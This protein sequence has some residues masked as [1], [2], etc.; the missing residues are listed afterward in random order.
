MHRILL[1]ECLGIEG[2][3][4]IYSDLETQTCSTP[5]FLKVQPR[6]LSP[7]YSTGM[8][9]GFKGWILPPL[10]SFINVGTES[11]Q[12]ISPGET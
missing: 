4:V 1:D 5:F 12:P 7:R 8:R 9:R 2:L 3:T 11:Y 10:F 6:Q